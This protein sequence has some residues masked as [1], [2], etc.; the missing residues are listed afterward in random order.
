MN[1]RSRFA[2]IAL[3]AASLGLTACSSFYLVKDPESGHEY[4]TTKL[5]RSDSGITFKDGKSRSTITLQN[6][7]VTEI[8]KNQYAANTGRP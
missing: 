5:D 3:A 4:Y 2:A 6:A 7:E 8:T 1:V